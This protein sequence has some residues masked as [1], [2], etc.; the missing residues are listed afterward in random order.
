MHCVLVHRA[1]CHTVRS[2]IQ[3]TAARR[4]CRP[5]AAPHAR[6]PAPSPGV[7]L[8]EA[9][10]S[11]D[12]STNAPVLRKI[13]HEATD[14]LL[15]LVLATQQG[16]ST[17]KLAAERRERAA[18]CWRLTCRGKQETE[19]ELHGRSVEVAPSYRA[20]QLAAWAASARTWRPRAAHSA[21]RWGEA[22]PLAAPPHEPGRLQSGPAAPCDAY[23]STAPAP[24]G[25]AASGRRSAASTSTWCQATV[26]TTTSTPSVRGSPTR[27]PPTP[28]LPSPRRSPAL[29]GRWRRHT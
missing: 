4:H 1:V 6:T 13:V 14:D 27:A 28:P 23:P 12:M 29:A 10:S 8:L 18:P 5:R 2:T 22:V 11:P 15:S 7:W 25:I 20:V 9:N 19:R 24:S 17:T 26:A 16:V 21:P 3:C